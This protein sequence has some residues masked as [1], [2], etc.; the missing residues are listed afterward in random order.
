VRGLEPGTLYGPTFHQHVNTADVSSRYF[1]DWANIT[2]QRE[3]AVAYDL[4]TNHILRVPPTLKASD[5]QGF[6]DELVK[7]NEK[8]RG[9]DPS[10][11]ID[12]SFVDA[13]AAQGLTR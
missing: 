10:S 2:D 3:L 4:W 8:A 11:M 13:A 9:F 6:V 5:F 1:V 7:R 12:T